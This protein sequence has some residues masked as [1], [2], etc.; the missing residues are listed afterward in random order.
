MVVGGCSCKIAMVLLKKV[1]YVYVIHQMK[2][3]FFVL[4]TD[5]SN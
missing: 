1:V 2:E 5:V 3:R 4:S